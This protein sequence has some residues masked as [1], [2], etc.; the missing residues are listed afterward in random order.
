MKVNGIAWMRAAVRCGVRKRRRRTHEI[1]IFARDLV[2]LVALN[3]G[4]A[5]YISLYI[6]AHFFKYFI[7]TD[8]SFLSF[9]T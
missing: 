2:R 6:F 8:F 7:K 3:L 1:S 5:D 9:S 4:L